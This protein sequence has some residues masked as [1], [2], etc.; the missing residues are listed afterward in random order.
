MKGKIPPR[1]FKSQQIKQANAINLADYYPHRFPVF[2]I[3]IDDAT[4]VD[5]DDGIWLVELNNGNFE[6]QISI[7]DVSTIIPKDSPVDEEALSRVVTLYHTTVPTPMLPCHISTNLGSLEEEK[8]RLALTIFFHIDNSGNVI[9]F[10]IKETIF[11]NK[12][13]F[14][15]QEVEKIL[16]NP[17]NITEHKLLLKMQQVAQ[18]IGRKRGGNSGILTANGYV[19]ED[20]NLIQ[21]NVNTHQLIAELMI[22]TNTTIANFLAENNILALYRTQDVGT[23]D[24]ELV[25]KTMGHCLV[26][27]IYN[28]QVKPHVGLC[29]IAYIHFTSPLR[30]FVDLVNHRIVKAII[31]QESSP[32]TASELDNICLKINNF[33]QEFKEDKSNFLKKQRQEV[34]ENNF[35]KI[36]SLDME[37]IS[38]DEFSDLIQYAVYNNEIQKIF[39][40]IKSRFNTLQP[41]DFYYIWFRCKINEFLDD[42]NI[43]SV[44][45]LLI[46][47]QSDNSLIEYKSEYCEV[48]KIYFVYCYIDGKTTFNPAEDTKKSKAKQKAALATIKGY[49][50]QE[51]TINPHP[52]SQIN[53]S[54]IVSNS[55]LENAL[56]SDFNNLSDKDFSKILDYCIK[57][58]FDEII[59]QKIE[60]RINNLLP[61]DLYKIWFQGK[62][63]KF[64]NYPNLN[65]VSVLLIHSQLTG[66]IVEYK[67]DYHSITKKYIA[68]CYVDNLTHQQPQF[69]TK[70]IKA[71]QKSSLAYIESYL[72]DELT[73]Q[74][75]LF[76]YDDEINI[77]EETTSAEN[78]INTINSIETVNIKEKD[79]SDW[80]SKLYHFCQ[81]NQLNYPEYNFDNIDGFFT[82]KISLIYQQ[83]TIISKGYGK[84]KKDAKQSASHILFIQHQL[85]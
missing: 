2:G 66:C 53:L 78:L 36:E 5:R 48:R 83:K 54:N 81:S 10:R 77:L 40:Y 58:H 84:N 71:K 43:D 38:V 63:N 75:D 6:L 16:Q 35:N 65:G 22:L 67:I 74:P 42:E 11:T 30:R 73:N 76:V 62:V 9:S 17:Q 80:V 57:T 45:V 12:K 4:T 7:T 55:S 50:H 24:F 14:S 29:L 79:E 27:A 41:K 33:Y 56:N 85:D 13:A 1:K 37:K 51:L 60:A 31:K 25:K 26:P 61:K 15:Y 23:T 70:K 68:Y 59:F 18:L 82:C 46:K 39:P 19:D 34:I 32:Y 64:L 52:I 21:E 72:R 49:L 44:S 8:R 69:D 28:S 3:T 47:S 20:G